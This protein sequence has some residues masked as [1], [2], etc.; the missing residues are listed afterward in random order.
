M[1]TRRP[2][3]SS[4]IGHAA[5]FHRTFVPPENEVELTRT[6]ATWGCAHS[7]ALVH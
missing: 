4:E 6:C 7:T 5:P 3:L 1:T 2:R